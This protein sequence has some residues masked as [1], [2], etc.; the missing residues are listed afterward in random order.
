MVPEARHS[1]PL[2]SLTGLSI[3]TINSLWSLIAWDS[4]YPVVVQ[5][6]RVLINEKKMKNLITAAI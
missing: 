4:L 2:L 5:L 3:Q 1:P 6:Q